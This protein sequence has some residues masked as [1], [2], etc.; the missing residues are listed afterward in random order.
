M[1]LRKFTL[2]QQLTISPGLPSNSQ[3]SIVGGVLSGM[4]TTAEALVNGQDR[5]TPL[6]IY[7]EANKVGTNNLVRSNEFALTIVPLEGLKFARFIP[8]LYVNESIDFAYNV[9]AH[10]TNPSG[11]GVTWTSS[12]PLVG[13]NAQGILQVT[14]AN[15]ELILAQPISVVING[16]DSRSHIAVSN[17]I[18]IS[19]IPSPPLVNVPNSL[20]DAMCGVSCCLWNPNEYIFNPSGKPVTFRLRGGLPLGSSLKLAENGTMSGTPNMIDVRAS[21]I[22]LIVEAN[23]GI[24][25]Q[26]PFKFRVTSLTP[27][28]VMSNIPNRGFKIGQNFSFSVLPFFS[29]PGQSNIFTLNATS[30]GIQIDSAGIVF[31]VFSLSDYSRNPTV[32]GTITVSNVNACGGG[33]ASASFLISLDPDFKDPTTNITALPL[34]QLGCQTIPMRLDFARYFVD[35]QG[36]A[37]NYSVTGLRNGTGLSFDASFGTLTG[38]PNAFD[39]NS[40]A[41]MVTVCAMNSGGKQACLPAISISFSQGKLPPIADPPIP[42]PVTA[43]IGDRFIGY[44]NFHF[45][46]PSNQPLVFSVAGLPPGSGM[47]IGPITGIFSGSPNEAD[48]RASPLAL[49][50]FASNEYNPTSASSGPCK[51]SGGRARADF[52]LVVQRRPQPPICQPIP[53]ATA[54]LGQFFILDV[55][56]SFRSGREDAGVEFALR[57]IPRGSSLSIDPRS[58]IISGFVTQADLV[59][60]PLV[61]TVA[62]TNGYGACQSTLIV[63]G[64]PVTPPQPCP[65]TPQNIATQNAQAGIF[66]SIDLSTYFVAYQR[67]PITYALAGLPRGSGFSFETQTGVLSGTPSGSDLSIKSIRLTLEA[68]CGGEAQ[69]ASIQFNLV[70]AEQCNACQN[71]GG[72]QQMCFI[73]NPNFCQATCGCNSGMVLAPDQ[74]SCVPGSPCDANNGGCEKICTVTGTQATCSCPSGW[75]LASNGRS[76]NYDACGFK[77]GNCEQLCITS[78]QQARCDCRTG[79][80]KPDGKTCS[81]DLITIGTIPPALVIGC[82]MFVFDFSTAFQYG[83]PNKQELSF[84]ASGLPQASGL[85]M[86]KQ[87]LL[88]GTPTAADCSVSQPMTLTVEARAGSSVAHAVMFMST[89]CEKT[90]SACNSAAVPLVPIPVAWAVVCADF[91]LPLSSYFRQISDSPR[92]AVLGLP[93]GSGLIMTPDGRLRGNPTSADCAAAPLTLT[94]VCTDSQRREFK[95][96]LNLKFRSC[97]CVGPPINAAVRL[98]N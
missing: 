60:P 30:S 11:F 34:S 28:S 45:Y 98:E 59:N 6:S 86:T 38:K 22:T 84:V 48:L 63:N 35:P 40:V 41:A 61:L 95:G 49:S 12:H 37:L 21:P 46:D 36:L 5:T 93:A 71:N 39:V 7:I 18:T 88:S 42:S 94:V 54:Q 50:V 90:S 70:I 17:A 74:R 73:Q 4:I 43:I 2:L 8:Q 79:T 76:C 82:Q 64:A 83:G 89:F 24:A 33:T 96:I 26:V 77:N 20:P 53:P 47:G 92:F 55:S 66:F 44:F 23:N 72:C 80:L 19:V 58:G 56:P 51:G 13:V 62:V 29:L 87:G 14:A 91:E 75:I 68:R 1:H 67:V 57:N 85:K 65:L 27:P 97:V 16:T 9:S 69:P 15:S 78:G 31:G 10:F 32:R 81:S 3:L 25:V 52:I